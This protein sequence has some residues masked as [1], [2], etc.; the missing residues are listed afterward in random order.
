MTVIEQCRNGAGHPSCPREDA[1][2]KE[3]R[4]GISSHSA[5]N[6]YP[7]DAGSLEYARAEVPTA[8]KVPWHEF[9]QR[10]LG[11]SLAI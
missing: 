3:C 8:A 1:L 6:K 11:N 2:L 9:A 7:A 4:R 5:L 10:L